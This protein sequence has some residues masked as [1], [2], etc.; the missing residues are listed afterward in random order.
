MKVHM[1]D[2]YHQKKMDLTG[3]IQILDKAVYVSL[4]TNTLEK[5]MNPSVLFLSP[6]YV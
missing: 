4:C 1:Y 5:G 2:S 3:Q 6:S